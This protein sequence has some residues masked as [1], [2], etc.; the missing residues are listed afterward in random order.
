MLDGALSLLIRGPGLCLA[1]PKPEVQQPPG[2]VDDACQGEHLVPLSQAPGGGEAGH[3]HRGEEAWYLGH[4]VGD[5][6]EDPRVGTSHL[7][8]GEVEPS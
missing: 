6:K 7:G 3:D 4:G 1:G 8:V 5:T 2:Q